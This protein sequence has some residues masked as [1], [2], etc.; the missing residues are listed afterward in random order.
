MSLKS[1]FCKH[2]YHEVKPIETTHGNQ[3]VLVYYQTCYK[4]GKDN[5]YVT[6][7]L[8]RKIR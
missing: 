7:L 1:L 3:K 5:V 6:D 8:G 2:E 4:C